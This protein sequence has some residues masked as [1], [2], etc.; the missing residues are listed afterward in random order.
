MPVFYRE[1]S[2]TEAPHPCGISPSPCSHCS[3]LERLRGLSDPDD[4][5]ASKTR[6]IFRDDLTSDDYESALEFLTQCA[7]DVGDA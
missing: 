7:I 3:C 4:R 5:L 2:N 1:P 6:L